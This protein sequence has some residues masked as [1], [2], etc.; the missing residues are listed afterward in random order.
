MP[1]KPVALLPRI[2]FKDNLDAHT[3]IHG[4][5]DDVFD[6]AVVVIDAGKEEGRDT[7]PVGSRTEGHCH[8]VRIRVRGVGLDGGLDAG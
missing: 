5:H 4:V 2:M 6:V 7:G 8:S 1:A 3:A